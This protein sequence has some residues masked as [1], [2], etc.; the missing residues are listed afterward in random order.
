MWKLNRQN[1]IN[2][3]SFCV[4]QLK[5]PE[6]PG[7]YGALDGEREDAEWSG[8]WTELFFVDPP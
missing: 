6:S 8:I 2:V 1:S 7:E 5:V 4:Q 3:L